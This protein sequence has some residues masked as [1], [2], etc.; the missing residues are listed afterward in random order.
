[1]CCY[2]RVICTLTMAVYP[3]L[4][5]TPMSST[6]TPWPGTVQCVII[7]T[8]ICC[9]VLCCIVLNCVMRCRIFICVILCC[10]IIC[11][12]YDVSFPAALTVTN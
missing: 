7:R 3:A 9:V 5:R 4:G 1:M 12:I 11:Y 8:V 2:Y 10:I 6:Q